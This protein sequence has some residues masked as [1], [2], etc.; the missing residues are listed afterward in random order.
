MIRREKDRLR[1]QIARWEAEQPRETLRGSDEALFRRFLALPQVR[2]ADTLLLF[3]GMRAEPRTGYLVRTL[4][5]Q[6]KT[7][8]LPRCRAGGQMTFH[9]FRGREDLVRHRFGM[10][11][12]PAD[13]PLLDPA[14]AEAA[15]IPAMCYDRDGMRLGR[16]G[17]YYDRFL[18]R[19]PGLTVGLCRDALLRD[20]VPVEGH[21]RGV[22]L[23]LTETIALPFP[24]METENRFDPEQ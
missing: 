24:T 9:P 3:W 16:G 4:A 2:Q 20:A 15:L 21:D 1:R 12:P 19:Y 6:G 8:G 13:A 17:G 11:E 23:V 22:D 7:V 18:D 10:L 5:E 14:R